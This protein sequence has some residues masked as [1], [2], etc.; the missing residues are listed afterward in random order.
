MAVQ[1]TLQ[2][3]RRTIT[4]KAVRHLRQQGVLPANVTGHHM[5]PLAI[6]VKAVEVDKLLKAYGRTTVI[7]LSIAPKNEQQTAM[8]GH[9]QRDPISGAIKHI[10]FL[11]V[12]MNEKMRAK[13]ALHPTGVAPAVKANVGILLQMVNQI[14]VEALPN[15]LPAAIEIDISGLANV[16]DTVYARD[17]KV[18][19]NVTLLGE[20]DEPLVKISQTRA[21][22]EAEPEAAATE[23]A[24]AG[25][26]AE[27][28]PAE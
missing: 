25:E 21:S 22:V 28:T 7:R 2:A 1:A 15:D 9:V 18:P 27:A 12:Q 24:P 20:P 3:E 13:I 16:D 26:S 11:V 23:A 10:D 14:E 5:E 19:A 17:L 6:Q 8:I 4:G